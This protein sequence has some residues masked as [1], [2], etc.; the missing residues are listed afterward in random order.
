MRFP[1][2]FAQ[3]VQKEY[4]G[5]VIEKQRLEKMLRETERAEGHDALRHG[6]EALRHGAKTEP[7]KKDEEGTPRGAESAGTRS[8]GSSAVPA[9]AV[10]SSKE[11]L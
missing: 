11:M 1:V 9:A 5:L 3:H 2:D 6:F 7:A 8:D 4:E 10:G